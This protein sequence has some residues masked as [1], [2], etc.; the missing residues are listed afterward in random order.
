MTA[1]GFLY[2]GHS[3]EDDYERIEQLLASDVRLSVVHTDIGEDAHRVD[4]LIEMGAADRLAAGVEELRLAGAEAVVWACTSG[5]FVYGW[6][7][8]QKQVRD[9]ARAAGMPASSTSFAF[10]HAIQYLGAKK[11]A[12]A[13][14]YPEDVA[15]YFA[16]FLKGAGVEVTATRG[17]GIITA[18]E[19][20]TWGRDEVIELALSGDHPSAEVLLLPDTALHTAAYVQELEQVLGKPVLTANQ[21]SVWEGLRLADRKVPGE[22]LGKLFA[23]TDRT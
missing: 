5:S 2:P 23:R 8:A 13:A 12:I 3:A 17:S 6:D 10:A 16:A 20:G 1:V 22:R 18:A 15:A 7:G 14:T 9:L 4:A 19:V 21:V 11:V